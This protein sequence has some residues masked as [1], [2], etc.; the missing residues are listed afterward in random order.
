MISHDASFRAGL[1]G[2]NGL[3]GSA[4]YSTGS[5]T[6]SSYS[7]ASSTCSKR[8]LH[9]FDS[10][11]CLPLAMLCVTSAGLKLL[12][13]EMSYESRR[14]LRA[15]KSNYRYTELFGLYRDGFAG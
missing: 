13:L 8:L 15:C 3:N 9:S 7:T 5:S 11:K 6:C 2:R 12:L 1:N 14:V 10:L 4:S